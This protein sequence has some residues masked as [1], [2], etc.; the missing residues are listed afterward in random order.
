MLEGSFFGGDG[1]KEKLCFEQLD[2]LVSQSKECEA[3]GYCEF[4]WNVQVHG[5]IF[6]QALSTSSKDVRW[7]GMYDLSFFVVYLATVLGD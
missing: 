5:P 4:D 6:A 2:K 1:H 3:D 7:H